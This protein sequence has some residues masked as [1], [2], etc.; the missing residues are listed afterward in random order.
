[1]R[2]AQ[3]EVFGPVLAIIRTGDVDEALRVENA[4]PYGNAA[5]AVVQARAVATAAVSSGRCSTLAGR[6]G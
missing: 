5:L 3:D 4:S 1:M 2:I 6:F